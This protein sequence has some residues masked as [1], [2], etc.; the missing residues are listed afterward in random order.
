MVH[1]RF[2]NHQQAAGIPERPRLLTHP[3]TRGGSTLQLISL[4]FS[5]SYSQVSTVNN[6]GKK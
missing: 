1:K 3:E 6:I 2:A 4:H 5:P